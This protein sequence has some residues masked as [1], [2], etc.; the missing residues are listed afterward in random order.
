MKSF[1]GGEQPV[2]QEEEEEEEE[3]SDQLKR[4]V[5]KRP[6]FWRGR[7]SLVSGPILEQW[8]GLQCPCR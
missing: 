6:M 2:L 1:D 8:W 5:K 4:M 7:W 3:M